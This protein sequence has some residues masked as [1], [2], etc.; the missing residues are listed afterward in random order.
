MSSY[1]TLRVNPG[2]YTE[3]SV[4]D[5]PPWHV[6]VTSSPEKGKQVGEIAGQNGVVKIVSRL[7][8]SQLKKVN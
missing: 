3:F 8:L 4:S 6:T 1:H 7:G 2:S 5:T